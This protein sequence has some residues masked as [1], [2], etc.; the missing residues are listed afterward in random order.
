MGYK[1]QQSPVGYN[2]YIFPTGYGTL[3]WS[4]RCRTVNGRFLDF[5]SR[6]RPSSKRLEF[7]DAARRQKV[8]GA[9]TRGLRAVL[10]GNLNLGD[11]WALEIA[12][13]IETDLKTDRPF[14]GG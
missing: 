12:A 2:T 7:S 13:Q 10:Y 6:I 3:L 9:R 8:V 5:P 1:W 4:W 14:L 11:L